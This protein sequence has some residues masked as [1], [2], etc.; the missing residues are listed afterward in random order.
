MSSL[1]SAS[2]KHSCLSHLLFT[3]HL[4]IV[5]V[6]WAALYTKLWHQFTTRCSACNCRDVLVSEHLASCLMSLAHE[7][8]RSSSTVTGSRLYNFNSSMR[9]VLQSSVL[10]CNSQLWSTVQPP[11]SNT[12]PHI[13]T[14]KHVH[15]WTTKARFPLP[16]LTGDR[17]PLPGNTVLTGARF[18]Y[19]SWQVVNSASGNRAL[20]TT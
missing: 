11:L 20:H 14:Y 16:E 17:F 12:L 15:S 6:N 1:S 4:L 19:P 3:I 18:H 2:N 9:K 13:Q 10:L 5:T 8:C 7:F